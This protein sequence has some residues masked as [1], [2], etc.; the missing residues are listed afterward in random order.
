MAITF[1]MIKKVKAKRPV[2]IEGLPGLGLVGTIAASYLVEKLDMEQIGYVTSDQFPPL[3][4][5][6]NF[7]PMY[8]IRIYYSK[9]HN[10][11]VLQS[12]FVIPMNMV[13]EF[14]AELLKFCDKMKVSK[15]IS[16]GSINIKGTQDTVYGITTDQKLAKKLL[17]MN[18]ELIKEGAT[19]GVTAVLLAESNFNNIP[20]TS[21]LSE[22]HIEYADPRASAMVLTILKELLGIK[23]KLEE[24]EKEAKMIEEK[25]KDVI[26]KGSKVQENYKQ[27]EDTKGL[28]PMYG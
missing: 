24:L 18:V 26:T 1:H 17:S 15:I 16:L 20:T 13:N 19:T 12:E 5:I 21:L 7:I 10:L 28:S 8:P 11:V 3:I 6:H 23:I 25:M 2:L 9:A 4:A 14:T 27:M 22:A